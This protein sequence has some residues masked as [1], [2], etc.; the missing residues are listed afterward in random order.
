MSEEPV[1]ATPAKKPPPSSSLAAQ[2]IA[3]QFAVSESATMYLA[4]ALDDATRQA[5]LTDQGLHSELCYVR[6]AD[7]VR[8]ANHDEI[9]AII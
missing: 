4:T 6:G 1:I 9:V 8:K 3:D 7:A 5:L 2:D